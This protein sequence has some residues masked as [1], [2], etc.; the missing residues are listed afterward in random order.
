MRTR[1]R[2][3]AQPWTSIS[4]RIVPI[5]RAHQPR[6]Q[7]AAARPRAQ[8]LIGG[9]VV[10]VRLR[11]QPGRP[12]RCADRRSR[13]S[14]RGWR[15]RPSPATRAA[16][17]AGPSRRPRRGRAG[18][19]SAAGR[20]R[21]GGR[22]RS[23]GP[24]SMPKMLHRQAPDGAGHPVAVEVERREVGRADDRSPTSI[25]MPSTMARKS[26]LLQAEAPHRLGQEGGA[27]RRRGRRRA[28]P[29]SA[30]QPVELDAARSARGRVPSSAMSSTTRQ[31]A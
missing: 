17:R 16:G 18:C 15:C 9:R 13:R 14:D 20:G 22:A 3:G 8:H 30:R 21:D 12:R 5:D 27:A 25:S 19:W 11:G 26:A 23:P 24:C 6:R 29:R 31:K 28:P 2:G 7:Q 10:L 4:R 1:R